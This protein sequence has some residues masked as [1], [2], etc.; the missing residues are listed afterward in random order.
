VS[1]SL[2]CLQLAFRNLR[3]FCTCASLVVFLR[4]SDLVLSLLLLHVRL[5]IRTGHQ[6][7]PTSELRNIEIKSVGKNFLLTYT[8]LFTY[9]LT[10]WSRVLLEK[11]TGSAA[12]QEIPH[13]LWNPKVH[14]RIHTCP[15][16]VPT[17]HSP[18]QRL[19]LWMYRKK[20]SFY[21][22]VLLAPRPIP[23]L[24]DHPLS[25]VRY[26]LFNIF[27]AALHIG[28]HY[29]IRNLRTR[30]AVVTGTHLSWR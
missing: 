2:T 19:N 5:C 26:C 21:G 28:G 18:D 10:P 23:H 25:A 16:R 22:D 3:F 14:F 1:T 8:Y 30:H 11:L 29:S 12:S 13:I 27:A 15:P 24:E 17:I 9:L 7:K 4:Y 20:T 6:K